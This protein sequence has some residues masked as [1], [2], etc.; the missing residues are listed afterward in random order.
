MTEQLDFSSISDRLPPQNVD[1]EVAIL[2]GI[3]LD[4]N[5]FMRV[6]DKLDV[7]AFYVSTHRDIYR[8]CAALNAKGKATDC[9]TV[10]SWLSDNDLLTHIGGRSKL[11]SL[12]DC[13]VGTVNIDALA[14][15]VMDKY[16]RRCL[17][18][19]ANQILKLGYET[20]TGLL[21]VFQKAESKLMDVTGDAFGEAEPT[22]LADIMI[23][24]YSRVEERHSGIKV[25][26]P[27]GFYDLDALLNGGFKPGKLITVAARPACGKSSFLGKIALNMAFNGISVAIFSM[28]M[29]K[30]EWGDRF[31]SQDAKIES[32]YLQTGRISPNHWD[33][34]SRSA[35]RLSELPVYIDD[36]PTLNITA[37]A[38]KVKRLVAQ[39]GQLG[40]VG[41]DYL[42]LID[43]IDTNGSN[44]A[45]SIGK[46]TRALKQ[47]SRECNVPIVLLCQ[48]NRALEGRQNKRPTP[49][50]LRDSGRIEEDSDIIITL[51]RDE[52]YDPQS[53][54]RGIAEIS[55]NKHR[56][57][58]TGTVKLLFDGQF[59][60]FKNFAR[61]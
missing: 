59:T 46:V 28:E 58:P 11:M 25:G 20:E 6:S 45:F 13:T 61:G 33:N 52:I 2:G 60:E 54:D 56:G 30:E 10:S 18:K 31:L 43:G 27:T 42:G 5:A 1:A 44:L 51:Y 37:V 48:L 19:A 36:S 15:L 12:I 22:A 7:N 49:A 53:V 35:K 9:L 24:A 38:A 3:L 47:L 26:F 39:R 8:A 41:I 21:E 34:L 50:D 4:P 14:D 55:I 57:G 32:S 40:M 23:D 29:N 17:I 16:R